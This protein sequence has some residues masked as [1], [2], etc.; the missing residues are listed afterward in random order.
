ME[1]LR[2]EPETDVAVNL[3]LRYRT[4]AE[5]VLKCLNSVT[6]LSRDLLHA[7][8]ELEGTKR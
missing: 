3:R 8:M 5:Y 1:V 7:E 6:V 2:I 4:S